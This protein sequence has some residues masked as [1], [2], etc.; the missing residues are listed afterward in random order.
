MFAFSISIFLFYRF[1]NVFL[2]LHCT[3]F[4]DANIGIFFHTAIFFCFFMI[5]APTSPPHLRG[6]GVVL[7]LFLPVT[8]PHAR[9]HTPPLAG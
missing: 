3:I 8:H 5:L 7:P 9:G 1:F 2:T 4:H 6:F